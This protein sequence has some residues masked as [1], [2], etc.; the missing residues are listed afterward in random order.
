MSRKNT[1]YG[2]FSLTSRQET[3][4]ELLES[5]KS[6]MIYSKGFHSMSDTMQALSPGRE[7]WSLALEG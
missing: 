1:I 6:Q 4:N 5:K 3:G 2:A 7:V